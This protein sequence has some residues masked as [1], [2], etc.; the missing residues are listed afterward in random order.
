M[1]RQKLEQGIDPGQAVPVF[2]TRCS[3]AS[4]WIAADGDWPGKMRETES[5]DSGIA[6]GKN[7]VETRA[8]W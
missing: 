5:A 6:S 8:E 3:P 2:A 4:T 7:V 1:I